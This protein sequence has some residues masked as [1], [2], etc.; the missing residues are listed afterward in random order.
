[1][2]LYF[3]IY[4]NYYNRIVKKE[5]SLSAYLEYQVGEP[6]QTVINWNPR[7][8]VSTEQ[9]LNSWTYETPD[10][11]LVVENNEIVSRWFV[12]ESEYLRNGQYKVSLY[13]DV[14]VDNYDSIIS[15]PCFIEKA[16][17]Q[18]I[19]DPA[20]YNNEDMTFNQIKT[21]EQLLFDETNC[22][23]IV[24][25]IPRDA[26]T[27]DP[28][29]TDTLDLD[30]TVEEQLASVDDTVVSVET[31]LTGAADMELDSISQYPFYQYANTVVSGQ[32]T[33]PTIRI[34]LT[35]RLQDRESTGALTT[36]YYN[37]TI[38]LDQNGNYIGKVNGNR[39]GQLMGYYWTQTN[40]NPFY[41]PRNMFTDEYA[42]QVVANMTSLA[43][44]FQDL[45]DY[46]ES[47]LT[48]E[49]YN[50]L[51]ADRNKIIYDKSTGRYWKI[52]LT[53]NSA[54]STE[55]TIGWASGLGVKMRNAMVTT[56]GDGY[57]LS[58]P[59]SPEDNTPFSFTS[60]TAY[61]VLTFEPVEVK[62]SVTVPSTRYHASE[63][64]YDI[65]CMPYSNSL[66]IKKSGV[67][68]ISKT[69][70][71]AA[72]TLAQ[73][74][75]AEVGSS[76]IYDVQLLPYCP[77]RY[78]IMADGTFDIGSAIY[79]D[80]I[81]DDGSGNTTKVNVLLWATSDN[82]ELNIPINIPEEQTVLD[83]KIKNE[84]EFIRIVAPN[85]SNSF[86]F[87]PQMNE[88]VDY[89]NILCH[90]KPFNPYIKVQPNFK[91]LYGNDF[92]DSRG[93]VCNGDFSLAQVTSAWADYELQNKNYQNIF[94]REIQ[95]LQVTNSVQRTREIA[96]AI[97]GTLSGMAGGAALGSMIIGGP[98][99][100]GVGGGLGA[101]ASGV[102]GYV[103]YKL[104][105]RLR[106][107]AL[108][109]KKD[110]FGYNLQNIQALPQGLAKTSAISPDN[111]YVPF[112]EFYS[113]TDTEKQ[114]LQ[115]KL[116]YDGYTIMRIG[117]I[118][119][120]LQSNKSYIKGRIIRIEDISDDFHM[121][122]AIADEIYKGVFI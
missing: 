98:V 49:Q 27:P 115:D 32:V 109:Y 11:L 85:F 88:G 116:T 46:V 120:Y 38:S 28:T 40:T 87:N 119:N 73:Q 30:E 64:P 45:S 13:R 104:N 7:D 54:D 79:S 35:Y 105:E 18:S 69:N 114:A 95:N 58:N 71:S 99:G 113:C 97:T 101:I 17:P 25:Y 3:L 48:P 74:I 19:R 43:N 118:A 50:E 15:A 77:V 66:E 112:I 84:T 42:R 83:K 9:I 23:W 53:G 96:G 2:D 90:Y 21:S 100:M 68:Y 121:L 1:M 24:G 16:V 44:D 86:Q 39:M 60:E 67:T 82:F 59:M 106:N 111:K 110:M 63:T 22:P 94:N 55:T 52:T 76:N 31:T 62:L 37:N 103:D 92:N 26:F 65:F 47:S 33:N 51:Y 93:L 107:E 34:A 10:Y 12:I 72:L 89:V 81:A 78:C 5:S 61:Q 4:N 75:A 41:V 117:S 91:G 36:Y 8:G 122:K 20:I 70:A 29:P 56:F 80:V 102:G 14:V 108:D 57:T 6:L